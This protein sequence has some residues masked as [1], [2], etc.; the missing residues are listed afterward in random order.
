ML[1]VPSARVGLS[2]GLSASPDVDISRAPVPVPRM[3]EME[4][5]AAP[6]SPPPFAMSDLPGVSAPLGFFDPLGFS[7][8]ASEGKC[9]FYREVEVKHGRVAMLAASGFVVGEQFHPF[10]GAS[11]PRR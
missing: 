11:R 4:A 1:V 2:V 10:F 9:R 5:E 6:L 3:L 8:D 7:T